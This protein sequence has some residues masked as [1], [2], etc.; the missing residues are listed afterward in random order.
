VAAERS[1]A[2]E[3]GPKQGE[4]GLWLGGGPQNGGA[5]DRVGCRRI[6]CEELRETKRLGELPLL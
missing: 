5:H 3:C 1:E 6:G 2:R 4:G